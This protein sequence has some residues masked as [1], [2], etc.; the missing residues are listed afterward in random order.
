MSKKSLRMTKDITKQLTK[1][2]TDYGQEIKDA[3][4][5]EIYAIAQRGANEL[6]STSPKGSTSEYA[7]D[8]KV[9]KI[10]GLD[11]RRSR[12]LIYNATEYR[13]THLLEKGHATREGGRTRAQP[14]IKPVEEQIIKELPGIIEQK[15]K[16]G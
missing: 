11:R 10:G 13:L 12:A 2:L 6:K 16:G 15:I 7:K 5:E 3:V 9:N 8:W 14:H 1:V 4:A